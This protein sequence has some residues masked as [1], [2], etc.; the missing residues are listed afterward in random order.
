VTQTG[1][2]QAMGVLR[3]AG[4]DTLF[5]LPFTHGADAREAAGASWLPG[6]VVETLRKVPQIDGVA[7]TLMMPGHVGAGMNRLFVT[8]QGVNEE[9]LIVRNHAIEQ[10]R[11]FTRDELDSHARVVALG[12]AMPEKLF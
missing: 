6:S 8:I 2:W 5:I 12:N 10:G 3:D 9:Y 4:S 11:F 1:R 7:G